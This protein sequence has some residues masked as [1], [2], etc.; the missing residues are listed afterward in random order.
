MTND[1]SKKWT[2]NDVP[3]NIG[4]I[5]SL[6]TG[7]SIEDLKKDH[8]VYSINNLDEA[9]DL[10]WRHEKRGSMIRVYADYDDDGICSALIIDILF[11]ALRIRNAVITIPRRFTDGYGIKENN[12]AD[13]TSGLLITVDNGIAAKEAVDLAK[14]KGIDVIILD[15]HQAR[16]DNNGNKVIPNADVI[17][18]PHVTGATFE[19]YCGAGLAYKFA[20]RVFESKPHRLTEK[21]QRYLSSLMAAFAALGTVGDAVSLTGENRTIVKRGLWMMEHGYCT[22]GLKLLLEQFYLGSYITSADIGYKLAPTVNAYGRLE[23]KGSRKVFRALSYNDKFSNAAKNDIIELCNKNKER[24]DVSERACERARAMIAASG[25]EN[26]N[27]LVVYDKD[28]MSGIAGLVA[29]RLTEEY[30]VPSIVFVPT[31]DPSIIKGSGRSVDW[32]ILTDSMNNGILDEHQDLIHTYGG[33]PAA[34]GI[35]IKKEN[36][37]AFRLAVEETASKLQRPEND[38]SIHYD[39]EITED[40]AKDVMKEL[41]VYGP[42]GAGNPDIVIRMDDIDLVPGKDG[43]YGTMGA[44]NQHL[45]LYTKNMELVWFDG[46]LKYKEMGEPHKVSVVG[47]LSRHVYKED[48]KLQFQVIDMIPCET[49]SLSLMERLKDL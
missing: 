45:R 29:G 46:T 33:H 2:K 12:I 5:V 47:I 48:S 23:D 9:V 4:E 25:M 44:T 3:A 1:L 43:F 11:L 7:M 16:T 35:S 6:R 19:D 41:D 34:C 32:A 27:F 36:L 37:E 10:F 18:D 24:K 42:Y 31:D 38:D 40:E 28:G 26:S 39:I 20:L 15:H 14:K 22:T 21:A 13:M 30:R 49:A 8:T 17:V